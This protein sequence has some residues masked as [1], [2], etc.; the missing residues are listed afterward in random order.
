MTKNNNKEVKII[1]AELQRDL[2]QIGYIYGK[3][4][5]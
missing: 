3:K 1:Q 2:K 4:I 5:A